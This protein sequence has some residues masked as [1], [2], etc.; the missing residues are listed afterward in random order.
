MPIA[1]GGMLGDRHAY[2][3]IDSHRE[4]H[5]LWR[6]NQAA[7][8]VFECPNHGVR[9]A[10]ILSLR[11]RIRAYKK[12]GVTALRVA[13]EGRDLREKLTTLR[14]VMDLVHAIN[15]GG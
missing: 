12:A 10:T 14:Q 1:F 8:R 5:L 6:E 3:L 4:I 2:Y 9:Y 11:K 15:A 7:S 13:P